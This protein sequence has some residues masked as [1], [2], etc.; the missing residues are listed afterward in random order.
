MSRAT[1][2]D[3]WNNQIHDLSE[4]NKS[5]AVGPRYC[6]MNR[7]TGRKPVLEP[8]PLKP[9]RKQRKGI[10]AWWI[11][12][13]VIL[14]IGISLF[15][16]IQTH[17]RVMS[18]VRRF[19]SPQSTGL[20]VQFA[21]HPFSE[22]TGIAQSEWGPLKYRLYVPMD[23]PRCGGIVL[24]HG[25]H[26]LGME[27]PRLVNFSRAL[28]AAGVQ[29]MTPELSDLADYR[30]TPNTSD[31][32]GYSAEFLSTRMKEARVGVVGLSF[33]GGLALLAATKPRFSAKMGF[34]LT[35]GAHDDLAR[36]ARFLATG[37]AEMPHG[38][39]TAF[40]AHE[41]GALVVAYSHIEDFFSNADRVPA[42]E[43]LRLWLSEMPEQS[44]DAA[45]RL[46][47]QGRKRFEQLL[48]HRDQLRE[49][50]LQSIQIHANELAA[51][52]PS[53]HLKSLSLPIY[54]LHGSA[55]NVIP[56]SETMWLSHEVPQKM[57]RAVLVSPTILHADVE[58][59]ATPLEQWKLLHFFAKILTSIDEL[60]RRSVEAPVAVIGL[61]HRLALQE[62]PSDDLCGDRNGSD[63]ACTSVPS[64][65]HQLRLCL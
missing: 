19:S 49:L 9:E 25:I 53:G 5:A 1:H 8:A 50:L 11:L 22:E 15:R 23:C 13:L 63:D 32:I 59:E 64:A 2:A 3:S 14:L 36:V 10:T 38:S 40:A 51:V 56:P 6:F 21:Q 45:N 41:Y 30:V 18:L 34:V 29:V 16:P 55:D 52:S 20:A 60:G 28:A 7:Q 39:T 26:R 4:T 46:T 62:P 37:I 54:L 65:R 43:A 12:S 58:E 31:E 27:E 47:P 57:L 44:R 24:L 33:A 61:A 42:R 48:Y 17:L 35:I